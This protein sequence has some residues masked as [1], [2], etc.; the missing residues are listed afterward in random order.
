MWVRRD[1]KKKGPGHWPDLKKMEVLQSYILLGNLTKA[2]ALN[3]VPHVTA[4]LWKASNWWVEQED[5]LR[6]GSK[7]QLSSKLAELVNKSMVVL[8]DRLENGD[9][10]YQPRTGA[11]VRKPISAEHANK[12]TTQLIDRTLAVE[13]AAKPEKVTTEGLDVHLQKLKE[14]MIKFAKSKTIEGERI[15]VPVSGPEVPAS[16]DLIESDLGH[17]SSPTGQDLHLE[18]RPS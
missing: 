10:I 15:D 9:F 13:K 6:R 3:N 17:A 14:E 2:A 12:I 11:F 16:H 5:E 8:A 1:K 4:K 18:R 7:L